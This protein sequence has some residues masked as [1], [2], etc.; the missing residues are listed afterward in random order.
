[1]EDFL[2]KALDVA[3][4]AAKEAGRIQVKYRESGLKV[5]IKGGDIRDIVTNADKEADSSI[6]SIISTAF[7]NH[8]IITEEDE[9]KKGNEY[10]WHVDPVDGTTNY[11]RRSKY[12]C[13][14]IGLAKGNE[15]LVGVVYAPLM[16]EMYTAVKGKGA[17]LNGKRISISKNEAIEDAILCADL[18][19]EVEK[20]RQFIAALERLAA[21]KSLR[22]CGSGALAACEVASGNADAYLNDCG[23][24]W[25]FA[26]A[27]LIIREAGGVA[28][29]PQ[30][31]EWSPQTGQGI[32][33]ANKALYNE[34]IRLIGTKNDK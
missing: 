18:C 28:K 8:T 21:A 2:S 19:H 16:D 1:M 29:S 24:S 17:F 22:I 14:S 13:V 26:A 12:F 25:D 11:S 34:I 33:A 32:V 6:R 9:A 7:P 10:S 15:L 27:A 5:S 4:A 30:G 3:V 23:S 31:E 20:R